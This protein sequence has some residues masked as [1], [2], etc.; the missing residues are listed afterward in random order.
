MA[1]EILYKNYRLRKDLFYTKTH[2]W[3]RREGNKVYVGIT[4][5]AQKKLRDIVYV[6]EPEIGRRVK[7]GEV[8]TTVESVKAVGEVYSPVSG[9]IVAWNEELG[10]DP[11]IITVDPYGKGWIVV[12]EMEDENELKELLNVDGY[13]K[14]LEKE[15]SGH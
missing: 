12:I 6:E 1:E 7:K 3:A 5:Y 2:E 15:E 11:S 13:I 9:T 8:V 4:D 14:I 10:V